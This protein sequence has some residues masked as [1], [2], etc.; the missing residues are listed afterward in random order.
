M[1]DTDTLTIR[2]PSATKDQLGQLA[3][4]TNRSKSFLAGE[5]IAS[6]VA[7]EM[8]IIS[9]IERGLEDMRAGRTVSQAD[10]MVRLRATVEAI[11]K[12]KK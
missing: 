12:T 10:A 7:R 8:E 1:S 2:L 11:S 5:A 9:G 6:Y 4:Q 3:A